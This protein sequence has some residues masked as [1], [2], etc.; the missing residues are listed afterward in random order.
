MGLFTKERITFRKL[1][2]DRDPLPDWVRDL[3]YMRSQ[4]LQTSFR[5][6][7]GSAHCEVIFCSYCAVRA[8]WPMHGFSAHFQ[9][10]H[11]R[12]T[13]RKSFAFTCPQNQAFYMDH[14]PKRPFFH[15]SK[16]WFERAL[17]SQRV[18]SGFQIRKG[19]ESCSEMAFG[20]WFVPLWTGP[21]F[22]KYRR[23]SL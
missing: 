18:K 7:T 21:E 22:L 12:I 23:V 2:S 4:A 17:R 14:D 20:T 9:N 8:D 13:F 1:V 3:N 19:S 11:A 6:R 16:A 10:A 5:S 15:V